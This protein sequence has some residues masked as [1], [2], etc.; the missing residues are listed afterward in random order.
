M[1]NHGA[2]ETETPN[3]TCGQPTGSVASW[4]KR[5]KDGGERTAVMAAV[6]R[7]LD[8]W[9]LAVSNYTTAPGRNVSFQP[10]LPGPLNLA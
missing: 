2:G 3:V 6:R 9:A 10:R 8:N 7:A 4:A 1:N 5:N